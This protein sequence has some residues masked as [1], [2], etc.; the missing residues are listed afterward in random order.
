MTLGERKRTAVIPG[1]LETAWQQAPKWNCPEHASLLK[2]ADD[3]DAAP[4]VPRR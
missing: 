1:T 2:E 3:E 4:C